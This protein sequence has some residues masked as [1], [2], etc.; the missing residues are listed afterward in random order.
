[1]R[2]G[3]TALAL[4]AGLIC[5]VLLDARKDMPYHRDGVVSLG[6]AVGVAVPSAD[7]DRPDPALER[8]DEMAQWD[9]PSSGRVDGPAAGARALLSARGERYRSV[10]E[11]VARD[12]ALDS[13]L[14]HAVIATESAYDPRAV[15]PKGAVGLMQLMP[16]TARRYGVSDLFDPAQNVRAGAR[17]LR[18]LLARFDNDIALSLAA[19]NAGERAVIDRGYRI[20]PYKETI[21]YVPTVLARYRAIKGLPD[22]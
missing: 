21:H 8:V 22:S 20:P 7:H 9:P 4:M 15:S 12:Y 1:M 16:E 2:T 19:Y 11:Q 5:A 18:D 3:S 6:S 14:L 10:V 13:A 17:Y